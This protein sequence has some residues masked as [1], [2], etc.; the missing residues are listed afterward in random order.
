M[1]EQGHLSVTDLATRYG[2]AENFRL[3]R[4]EV[5]GAGYN[6]KNKT[7][8]IGEIAF[9]K[10]NLPLSREPDGSLSLMSLF[11]SHQKK[12]DSVPVQALSSLH[13]QA[14]TE[15]PAASSRE[16]QKSTE[17][18]YRIRKITIAD[19]NASFTDKTNPG[20]PR[21]TL[22]DTT[23]K[24]ANLHGPKFTPSSLDFKST[25]NKVTPL[26][27]QGSLTPQPFAF[28]GNVN[29]GRLPL[30]D[31]EAYIPSNIRVFLLAGTNDAS[32]KSRVEFS[33][34]AQ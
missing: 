15:R 17:L 33:A 29:M 13:S 22:T 2:D 27:I 3:A 25:F 19:L 30:R 1:V 32:P 11:T 20:K 16:T 7:I 6:Q 5:K 8:D 21:F 23:L 24:L 14:E 10:G 31:F 26:R 4:F 18:S 34:T 12:S 28:R 9:L